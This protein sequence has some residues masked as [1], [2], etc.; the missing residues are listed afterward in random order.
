MSE[1]SKY[2]KWV[3]RRNLLRARGEEENKGIIGKLNR[4]IRA[5]EAQHN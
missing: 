4:K 2:L 3:Y 5:Y 1:Y